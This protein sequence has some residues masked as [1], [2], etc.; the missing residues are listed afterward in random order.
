M[1]DYPLKNWLIEGGIKIQADKINQEN[2]FSKVQRM[3]NSCW[4]WTAYVSDSG[5][6]R[7]CV[8]RKPCM[9][10]R[11]SYTLSGREIPHG[12]TI[13][14]ACRN[15]ACVNPFHLR[16]VTITANIMLIPRGV[17]PR[18]GLM[19]PALTTQELLTR[20]RSAVKPTGRISMAKFMPVIDTLMLKGWNWSQ[21]WQW[22]K[23]DGQVVHKTAQQFSSAASRHYKRWLERERIK[24]MQKS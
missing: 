14:H 2:F 6:G 20:A 4:I 11:V 21:I 23:D 15:R 18:V 22:L 8:D 16:A 19:T 24:S 12:F 5:Y 17:T 10:H 9:A 13:D 7:F 3:E 1:N